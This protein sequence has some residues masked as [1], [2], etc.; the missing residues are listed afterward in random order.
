MEQSP[1]T[2]VCD[3]Q[4]RRHTPQTQKTPN[5]HRHRRFIRPQRDT[6]TTTT[7]TMSRQQQQRNRRRRTRG[8]EEGGQNHGG[9]NHPGGFGFPQFF[10]NFRQSFDNIVH[11]FS[12]IAEG[13]ARR[14]PTPRQHQ[15][16]QQQPQQ[17]QPQQNPFS[18]QPAP[19]ASARAIR[20]LPTIRVAPEDL[21]DPN[22]RECCICLEE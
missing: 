16:Q 21:V 17:Q 4:Q 3:S 12:N 1:L 5:D 8:R 7:S 13:A 6:T 2:R 10:Q 22:N 19:P 9:Q 20:Q 14:T 18:S 15:Q 11:D